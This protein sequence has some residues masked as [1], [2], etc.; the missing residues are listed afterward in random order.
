M[1]HFFKYCELLMVHFFKYLQPEMDGVVSC[2]TENV[3]LKH[4]VQ[5]TQAASHSH[6]DE[7]T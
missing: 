7:L 3:S 4:N 5:S 2:F 6:M 1:E